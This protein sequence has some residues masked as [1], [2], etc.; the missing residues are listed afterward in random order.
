MWSEW[1]VCSETCD[2]G[3]RIR[4]Q[5]VSGIINSESE[6]CFVQS[7]IAGECNCDSVKQEECEIEIKEVEKVVETESAECIKLK[8]ADLPPCIIEILETLPYLNGNMS[9][10]YEQ[11]IEYSLVLE[12]VN[13]SYP[14]KDNVLSILWQVEEKFNFS[15]QDIQFSYDNL[16]G[17]FKRQ[18]DYI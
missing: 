18:F 4:I 1:S 10:F 15:M 2:L 14:L 3:A 7:C 6:K 17:L 11:R 9:I 8:N 12:T 5:N 16:T 13:I